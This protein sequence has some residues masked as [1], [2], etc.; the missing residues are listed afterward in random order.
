MNV[1]GEKRTIDEGQGEEDGGTC[2]KLIE[3]WLNH[4]SKYRAFV[5]ING[6]W[7]KLINIMNHVSLSA[8]RR[9]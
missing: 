1:T 3:N 7:Q 2:I 8:L 9:F 5:L 4:S 6:N